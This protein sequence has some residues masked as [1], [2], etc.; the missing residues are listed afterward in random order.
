MKKILFFTI[1]IFALF[2]C[3]ENERAKY[4]GGTMTYNLEK[5][6]ILINA[7]WKEGTLWVLTLDT[8]KNVHYFR[9]KSN[10][11]VLEGKVIFY[12]K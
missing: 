4:Y 6:E 3:T 11:G 12:E 2:S 5:N 8:V 1:V 10:L 9:E 7:T